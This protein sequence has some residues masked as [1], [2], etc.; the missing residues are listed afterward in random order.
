MAKVA[1]AGEKYGRFNGQGKKHTGHYS[2]DS[3]AAWMRDS[4]VMTSR[5]GH[6]LNN[7]EDR[8]K[9]QTSVSVDWRLHNA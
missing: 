1:L 9:K 8:R 5:T 4:F 6:Q 7:L 2:D 3:S